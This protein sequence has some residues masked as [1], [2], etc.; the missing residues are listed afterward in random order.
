M[1]KLAEIEKKEAEKNKAFSLLN[2]FK[3]GDFTF[4]TGGKTNQVE[5]SVA[6]S[7]SKAAAPKMW[8]SVDATKRAAS[9]QSMP[10]ISSFTNEK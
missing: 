10:A 7:K 2:A 1:R 9:N 5:S 6:W 3:A 4:G 8:Q